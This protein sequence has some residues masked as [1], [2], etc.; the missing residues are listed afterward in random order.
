[1]IKDCIILCTYTSMKIE[2]NG[3]IPP[4]RTN[5]PGSINLYDERIDMDA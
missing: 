2:P 5:E 4:N 1:M 3:R